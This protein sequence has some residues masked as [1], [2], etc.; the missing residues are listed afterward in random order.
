MADEKKNSAGEQLKSDLELAKTKT[1]ALDEEILSADEL[2]AVAGGR[3]YCTH[4]GLD[5]L[6]YEV[7]LTR[8]TA[9]I[10]VVASCD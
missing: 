3:D 6:S 4:L 1:D 8:G 2:E 9:M 7:K 5:D 10:N